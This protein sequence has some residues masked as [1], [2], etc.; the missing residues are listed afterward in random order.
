MSTTQV[1]AS[2]GSPDTAKDATVGKNGADA[3]APGSSLVELSRGLLIYRP[4][5]NRRKTKS[6]IPVASEVAPPR[7]VLLFGWMDAPA[8]IVSKYAQPW[9]DRFPNS[10]VIVRLSSAAIFWAP[11]KERDAMIKRLAELIKE[12]G[13]TQQ[14]RSSLRSEIERLDQEAALHSLSA[15]KAKAAKEQLKGKDVGDSTVTLIDKD[16]AKSM[17]GSTTALASPADAVPSGM[18]I[19]SFSDGGSNNVA[20]L[21]DYLSTHSIPV[22]APRAHI[23]DSSPGI[24]SARSS[25]T[26]I[27]MAFKRRSALLYWSVRI[28]M[29][30]FMRAMLFVKWITGQRPRSHIMR[31]KLNAPSKWT[32]PGQIGTCNVVAGSSD[33]SKQLLPRMYLY[34]KADLL[35]EYEAVQQ[36][37]RDYAQ[38]HKLP[39]PQPVEIEPTMSDEER[40][41]SLKKIGESP[42]QLRRF[43]KAPHCDLGRYDQD[44][45]WGHIDA[46]LK[47]H[48][49][50]PV[51]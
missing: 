43:A 25:S 7:V 18:F 35:I 40:K 24:S 30:A 16:E 4:D 13:V 33:A 39:E 3:P 46:F 8:R 11:P 6:E 2:S 34:S 1:Q 29:Y 23:F 49:R 20:L 21:L 12:E 32:W 36:H 27:S 37:A 15:D 38:I 28:A 48:A 44:G 45:Y 42:L 19:H 9:I 17:A 50:E 31:W 47:A 22:P 51:V 41:E 14:S 5:P 10:T 26:A